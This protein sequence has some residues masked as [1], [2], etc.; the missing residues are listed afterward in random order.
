MIITAMDNWKPAPGVLLEW[1][2]TERAR[3][4]AAAAT[5]DDTPPSFL[6]DGHIRSYQSKHAAGE[7]HRAY[8]GATTEFDGELDE[9]ALT[10]ALQ[11]YVLGHEG[12]RTSFSM[13]G[14]T[15]ARHRVDP[16]AVEFEVRDVGRT[17][18]HTEFMTYIDERFGREATPIGWPGFSFGA[19]RRPGSFTLYYGTDH[20]FSDGASQILV[21]SELADLYRAEVE[22][23]EPVD[24]SEISHSFLEYVRRERT[25]AAAVDHD[26]PAVAE[27]TRILTARGGVM[28]K[29]PLDLGLAPGETA[30]VRPVELDLLDASET[31]AFD[32][33][34][35]E[36]GA[37]TNGGIFAAI[38]ITDH[39]LAGVDDYFGITVLSTRGRDFAVSQ[40]WF[41]NFAP[42][43]FDVAGART[44]TELASVAQEGY[45]RAKALAAAPVH[46]VLGTLIASGVAGPD[47]ASS[48]NLLSYIDFRRFPGAGS[49][50]DDRAVLFTGEGRTANASMWINRDARHLYLGSQTP[51]TAIARAN[52]ERYHRHLASVFVA[53]ARDGDYVITDP[54][55][56]KGTRAGHHD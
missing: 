16:A 44:F 34:C 1:H 33:I 52:I 7:R 12:L 27:W 11:R 6:Q 30:P 25:A 8:L 23:T 5:V 13:D 17:D 56:T 9:S 54:N 46:A 20:A 28:P 49:P 21:I 15:I 40:G 51:D 24:T 50:T 2:P 55:T 41:C 39:E 37:R 14:D 42:V 19:V 36:S 3:E 48:P 29:F 18:D 45:A 31:D 53:V 26:S 22:G 32:K 4:L 38:A 43:S 10:C 47:V 35:H